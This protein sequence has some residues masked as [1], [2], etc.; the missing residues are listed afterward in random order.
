MA[1]AEVYKMRGKYNMIQVYYGGGKGK[2][3][4]AI[5][6]AVR[7]AGAGRKVLFVQFMKGNNTS[8]LA[9]LQQIENVEI[10]RNDRS[11]GFFEQMKEEDKEILT[12][13]HNEL[14]EEAIAFVRE[15]KENAV[16]CFI[17]LD[18]MTY[19]YNF[20]LL[21]KERLLDFLKEADDT[22]EIVITGRN[23]ADVITRQ[24]DY[25]SEIVCRRHPFERGVSAREGIEY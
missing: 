13:I 7:A 16:P 2:T 20:S 18:E 22:V 10:K 4:A 1:V 3:T 17:V 23:P 6:G 25:L 12:G 15:Q 14:L 24:A 9:V 11:F 19:A 8:E 5:G 21:R